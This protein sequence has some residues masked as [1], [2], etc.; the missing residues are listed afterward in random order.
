MTSDEKRDEQ[1]LD[2][3]TYQPSC[4][5]EGWNQWDVEKGEG[6]NIACHIRRISRGAGMGIKPLFSA[7]P[8]TDKQHRIQ[9][10]SER[11]CLDVYKPEGAPWTDEA[12]EKWFEDTAD[13]HVKLWEMS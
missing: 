11:I 9:G 13:R 5:D 3:L 1:F 7:V 10:T 6:R 12:A 2:W 8:L 4:L